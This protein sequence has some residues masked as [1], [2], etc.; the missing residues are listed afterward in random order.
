MSSTP[1]VFQSNV[2]TETLNLAAPEHPDKLVTLLATKA[3][4][5]PSIATQNFLAAS[6]DAFYQS[7]LYRQVITD[8]NPPSYS[9]Y[10]KDPSGAQ[11]DSY[12]EDLVYPNFAKLH[13]GQVQLVLYGDRSVMVAGQNTYFTVQGNYQSGYGGMRVEMIQGMLNQKVYNGEKSIY[14]GVSTGFYDALVTTYE[15]QN[16]AVT[17]LASD[18]VMHFGPRMILRKG[19]EVQTIHGTTASTVFGSEAVTQY[20]NASEIIYGSRIISMD[21]TISVKSVTGLRS[22]VSVGLDA[23]AVLGTDIVIQVFAAV[24]AWREDLI[25]AI[26]GEILGVKLKAYSTHME[27]YGVVGKAIGLCLR[28]VAGVFGIIRA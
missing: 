1:T 25:G 9:S 26:K 28:G 24:V 27:T 10:A 11:D 2:L 18:T 13:P 8:T 6:D 22:D 12:D 14:N 3:T 15:H 19:N 20:G 16:V 21:H 23:K 4:Q 7:P 17:S 5:V